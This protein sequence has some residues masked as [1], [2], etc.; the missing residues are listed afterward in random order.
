[1]LDTEPS[2]PV[3]SSRNISRSRAVSS[4]HFSS[5]S[6]EIVPIT[7]IQSIHHPRFFSSLYLPFDLYSTPPISTCVDFLEKHL[8]PPQLHKAFKKEKQT[9]FL[10]LLTPGKRFL[11]CPILKDTPVSLS[12]NAKSLFQEIRNYIDTGSGDA[13]A[14]ILRLVDSNLTSLT[15]ECAVQLLTESNVSN[16]ND[17]SRDS[18][19]RAWDLFLVFTERYE[20]SG[21][22][23]VL[24][25]SYFL[26]A[27]LPETN[28]LIQQAA[29]LCIV[30]LFPRSSEKK[31]QNVPD[32][33]I[34]YV[35]SCTSPKRLFGVSVAELLYKEELVYGRPFSR[36]TV[37]RFLTKLTHRLFKCA[38]HKT[39][40]MLRRVA[41]KKGEDELVARMNN[42]RWDVNL[43]DPIM[44]AAL[45][46]RWLRETQD[47]LITPSSILQLSG[48]EPSNVYVEIVEALPNPR[49]D[50]LMYMI[51]FLQHFL[52]FEAET[53]MSLANV[54]I[55]MASLFTRLPP[56]A[57]LEDTTAVNILERFIRCLI[58]EW[59]TSEAYKRQE[60]PV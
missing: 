46:K 38:G 11:S 4:D 48:N 60:M 45:M 2:A 16:F 9:S 56:R 52:V 25:L 6:F 50:T 39:E 36:A 23:R 19:L 21:E 54:L 43:D 10:D 8:N 30:R 13:V 41:S 12:S 58:E 18:V 28:P 17:E 57:S 35:V 29:T 34:S 55:C 15:F 14:Q 42:G 26:C 27:T 1:V 5:P 37:P 20:L 7:S 49:R 44:I 31:V 22:Q 51:G 40:G 59:D 3:I 24:L 47:P 33:I 53:K 32:P